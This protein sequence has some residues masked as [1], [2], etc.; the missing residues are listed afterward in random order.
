ML[1]IKNGISIDR[2][3]LSIYTCSE[4]FT[5]TAHRLNRPGSFTRQKIESRAGPI[6]LTENWI[7]GNE[8]HLLDERL[9]FGPAGLVDDLSSKLDRLVYPTN[10]RMN[11]IARI[12]FYHIVIFNNTERRWVEMMRYFSLNGVASRILT[13]HNYTYSTSPPF[14]KKNPPYSINCRVDECHSRLVTQLFVEQ[15]G[16][17]PTYSMN[18]R[19]RGPVPFSQ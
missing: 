12:F 15:M 8:A 16:L 5:R 19:V 14:K 10:D 9:G 11:W 1:L 4:P 7:N 18:C 2:A 6:Y 17:I 3:Y 13:R